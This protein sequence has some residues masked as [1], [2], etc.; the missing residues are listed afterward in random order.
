[1]V[2]SI[3]STGLPQVFKI[4]LMKFIFFSALM[5]IVGF[6]GLVNCNFPCWNTESHHQVYFAVSSRLMALGKY[7]IKK[8]SQNSHLHDRKSAFCMK[9]NLARIPM[10]WTRTVNFWG[11]SVGKSW[12]IWN[13]VKW[14]NPCW[15]FHL[16]CSNLLQVVSV[17]SVFILFL[18]SCWQFL[19]YTGVKFLF[20]WWH[21]LPSVHIFYFFYK[22]FRVKSSYVCYDGVGRSEH[23]LY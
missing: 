17:S 21:C 4:N 2:Q 7:D 23:P 6:L 9:L 8:I 11:R 14:Q 13:K 19:H 12:K 10:K 18:L 5:K 16:F 1:M 15:L 20:G 22:S 3:L